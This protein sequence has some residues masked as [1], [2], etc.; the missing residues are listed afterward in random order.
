MKLYA[1]QPNGHGQF[2]FFVAAE[3]EEAARAAVDTHIQNRQLGIGDKDEWDYLSAYDVKGWGTDY[4]R[5][6]AVDPLTVISNAND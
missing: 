2:S 4:Y 3:S 6:T 1:F 5:V